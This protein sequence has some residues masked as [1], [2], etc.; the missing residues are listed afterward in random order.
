MSHVPLSSLFYL[1]AYLVPSVTPVL[2]LIPAL[3]R[4]GDSSGAPS[5]IVIETTESPAVLNI[6]PAFSGSSVPASGSEAEAGA[7][8]KFNP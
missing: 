5:V 4:Y 8:T 2:N 1:I 6:T 7:E 3:A